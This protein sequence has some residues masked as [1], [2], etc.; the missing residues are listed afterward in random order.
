MGSMQAKREAL[1][2]HAGTSP[3]KAKREA[4]GKHAGRRGTEAA[5]MRG[6]GEMEHK[7]GEAAAEAAGA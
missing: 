1:G 2:T 4:L 7:P 6:R 5:R 3:R